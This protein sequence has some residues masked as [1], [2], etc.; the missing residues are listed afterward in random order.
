MH[1]MNSDYMGPKA[2][3]LCV[4]CQSRNVNL[5]YLE[6]IHLGKPRDKVAWPES[7]SEFKNMYEALR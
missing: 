4:E 5:L 3:P 1:M 6:T 2:K 7:V